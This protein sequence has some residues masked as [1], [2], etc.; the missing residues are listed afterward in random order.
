MKNSIVLIAALIF[1]T[2]AFSRAQESSESKKLQRTVRLLVVGS[3]PRPIFE[4]HGGEIVEATPPTAEIPP[5]QIELISPK[6]GRDD[7]G[8]SAG[9]FSPNLN[10]ITIIDGVKSGDNLKLRLSRPNLPG[11]NLE[12]T[13][14]LGREQWPLIIIS[15]SPGP[16]GWNKPLTKIL[17]LSAVNLPARRALFV[18]LTPLRYRAAF[19]SQ[20]GEIAA[21]DLHS[22]TLANGDAPVRF[23]IDAVGANGQTKTMLNSSY[24]VPATDRLLLVAF[25]DNLAMGPVPV[26]IQ[27]LT[28]P[29]NPTKER[30]K[31]AHK[32]G[33]G[34]AGS[35]G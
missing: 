13:C 4:L 29:A 30:M 22:F 14:D 35:G 15:R 17:D 9:T 34:E 10:R 19:D 20:L 32:N 23:R 26:G 8:D 24:R 5:R 21:N 31:S 16:E 7:D 1:T 11:E 28:D 25:P 6:K 3:H 27:I 12:T 33:P 18:N 2:G